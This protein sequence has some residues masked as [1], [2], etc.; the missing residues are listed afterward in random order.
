MGTGRLASVVNNL[1][2]A[3][4]VF[5]GINGTFFIDNREFAYSCTETNGWQNGWHDFF[6]TDD[7]L[8]WTP[9]YER[10]LGNVCRWLDH[11]M[12]P[13]LIHD[14]EKSYNDLQMLS[15]LKVWP[16]LPLTALIC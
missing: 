4:P 14:V 15:V 9:E 3:F 13:S 5:Y 6:I 16:K 7:V 1:F 2:L 10:K 12:T 8:N 11:S